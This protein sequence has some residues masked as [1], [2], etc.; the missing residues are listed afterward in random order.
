M[1]QKLTLP[2]L[3]ISGGFKSKRSTSVVKNLMNYKYWIRDYYTKYF[4]VLNYAND[5]V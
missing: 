4:K 2:E 5:K 1:I 3:I